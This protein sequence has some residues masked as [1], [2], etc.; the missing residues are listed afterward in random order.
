MN[1]LWNKLSGK[2]Q[3][4]TEPAVKDGRGL[5]DSE[6]HTYRYFLQYTFIPN[7]ASGNEFL[8]LRRYDQCIL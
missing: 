7:L 1:K 6:K 3:E 5:S 8:F 4:E 2:K